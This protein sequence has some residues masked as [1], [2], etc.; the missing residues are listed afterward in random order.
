MPSSGGIFDYDAKKS[1]LLEVTT[2]L[3]DPKV[4]DDPKKAQDLGKERSELEGIVGTVEKI[5]AGLRD[6]SDL[7]S[8]AKTE[9]DD[10]TLQSVESDVGDTKKLVEDLEFRRMFANP[11]DPNNCFIDINAG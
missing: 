8:L 3:E 11:M 4:W 10:D 9:G 6:S 7:F 1:R 2:A 5:D